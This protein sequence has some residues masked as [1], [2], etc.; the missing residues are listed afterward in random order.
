MEKQFLQ[1]VPKKE[2]IQTLKDN[3]ER[4][5]SFIYHKPLSEAE[6]TH[7]KDESAQHH[8]EL[9]KLE[10]AKKDFMD[11]HKATVN[12]IKTEVKGKLQKIRTRHEEVQE[13]VYLLAD[14]DEGMMGYYNA[15]GMLVNQRTLLPDERQFRIVDETTGTNN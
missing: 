5:E 3:A 7:L 13:D 4:M 14:Q 9:E 8:I 10:E 12:P 2:R 11:G 6:L 1:G 15:D